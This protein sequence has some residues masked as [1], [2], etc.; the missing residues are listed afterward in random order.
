M[1]NQLALTLGISLSLI[2]CSSAPT[3]TDIAKEERAIAQLQQKAEIERQAHQQ[4]QLEKERNQ[5]PDW[6]IE[7]PR[8]DT[9]GFYGIGIGRDKDLLA[10]TRKAKLQ[11]LFEIANTLRTEL[12]G[13]DTM[14]G[15]DNNQYRFIVNRFVDKVNI[16]GADLVK[17]E[18][19]VING[20]YHSYALMR[21]S[22]KQFDQ[23]IARQATP[24]EQ[25]SLEQAYQRLLK[26]IEP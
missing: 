24:Q 10:A 13:E 8:A 25:E 15:T 7:P 12:S 17:Q 23:L 3:K 18:I 2:G 19:Q 22:F 16:S 20:E 6:V 5:L 14:T 9:E 21:L 1:K 11:A 4:K 26:R